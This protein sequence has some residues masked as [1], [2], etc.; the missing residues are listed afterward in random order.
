MTGGS[1][2]RELA[3]QI[4]DRTGLGSPGTSTMLRPDTSP[5]Q[6]PASSPGHVTSRRRRRDA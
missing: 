3:L 1:A 5:V 2:V 4:A 6:P